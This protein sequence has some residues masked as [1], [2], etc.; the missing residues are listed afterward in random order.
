MAKRMSLSGNSRASRWL[1]R[2]PLFALLIAVTLDAAPTPRIVAV[3]DVH[4]AG[5]AFVSILQKAGVIDAQKRWIGGT[6]ILVQTG[7]LLDRGQDVRQILDLMM[8]LETQANAAGGR[9]QALMGNHEVMNL[10]GETRDVA[11]ELYQQF[12]DAKSE[13]K[14]EDAFQ[15]ASKLKGGSSIDKA[16]WMTAH[17]LGYIEYREALAAN[18]PYGK[19]LRSKPIAAEIGGTIFMHGGINLEFTTD[20]VDNLNKRVRR[21]LTEFEDGFRWLQQHDL[22]APFSTLSEIGKA[23]QNEWVKIDAKRKRD[24]LTDEDINEAKL[25]VPILKIDSSALLNANGPLWFRGYSTWTDEEG[26]QLMP[27][28]LKKYKVIRFVTGHTPQPSGHITTRFGNTLYLIDTG[29]L[30]GKFYPGG[31]PSALEIN[32]ETVTPLYVER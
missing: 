25:L 30:D 19:W 7:D 26:S 5:D 4:G 24:S 8:A 13:Q 2:L 12:A 17:P 28:L 14:R 16:E 22:A 11:P 20:S 23:A 29:M 21:E 3:G 9:V 31:R 1:L 10:I 6:T 27:A 15:A 18:A 32:G